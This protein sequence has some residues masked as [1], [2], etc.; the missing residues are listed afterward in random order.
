MRKDHKSYRILVM[1]DNPG[2]LT[3]VKDFLTEQISNPLIVHAGSFREAAVILSARDCFF[4]VILLDLALNDKSGQDLITEMLMLASLCPIIILSGYSDLD[5]SIKSISQGILDYLFK[6]DLNATTLYKSIIYAIERKKT[7]SDLKESEKR[8]SDLFYLSPQPMWLFDP[9]TYKF[10]Q[11]NKA[12]ANLYGY[13]QQEFLT[14]TL[15]DIKPEEDVA[16]AQ[17]FI[18]NRNL[19]P[20]IFRKT[21]RHHKKSGEI[22]E[23]EVYSTPIVIKDKSLISVIAI[24]VTEKNLYEH[25]IIKAIIKTQEDERYEIGSELHDNVCQILAASQLFL[26]LL[27]Q[28]LMPSGTELFDKCRENISLASDEIR[29]LSH[30]LAPVFFDDSTMEEAFRRLCNT[31]SIG[32]KLEI[33]LQ[34]GQ[35]VRDYPVSIEIQLN[36]YRILQEQ[37]RNILKYANATIIRVNV[38]IYNNKLTMSISDNGIGFNVTTAKAGIGLANMKRRAELFSGKFEIDSSVGT[39]CNIYIAIPLQET[40]K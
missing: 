11:V 22:I 27:K 12:T 10:I 34:F 13:S 29:N 25:K 30:R 20:G 16:E 17:E 35:I 24:D 40:N 4:D 26:G 33:L 28:S 8:Y 7:I 37:L 39:G 31:F 21:F 3:I 6:D 19:N 14:M 15:M 36:L 38:H 23:V 18:R 1:E 32:G 9:E 2:D 5:F